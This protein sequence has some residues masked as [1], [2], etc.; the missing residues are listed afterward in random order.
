M[1]TKATVTPIEFPNRDGLTIRGD[2]HLPKGEGPHPLVLVAHGFKGFKDWGFFPHLAESLAAAGFAALRFN[3]ARN[4][5]GDDPLAFDRLDLFRENSL[6]REITDLED[7]L[8]AITDHPTF[9]SVATGR[10]GLFG[11][12]RGGGVAIMYA[13]RE[14]RIRS[15]VTWASISD[16]RRFFTPEV[17]QSWGEEGVF[18]VENARTKQMMPLG[19]DLLADLADRTGEI[20]VL[21]AEKELSAPHL[22]LHGDDD[23]A[24]A[25][26]QGEELLDAST[27]NARLHRV[28]GAGHTFG[29]VHPF[30][31]AT[32]ELTEAV[33]ATVAHFR[34]TL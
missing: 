24:V 34:E 28:A 7:L 23:E 14:P 26:I 22:I 18:Y 30:A 32:A 21:A 9:E 29:A 10:P 20:D 33:E 15:L 2:L 27:G 1:S 11:H 8:A 17:L 25:V 13:A 5:V 12:S 16:P 31:G 6:S 4:G 19:A 3:F